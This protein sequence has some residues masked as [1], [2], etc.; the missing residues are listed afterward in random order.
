MNRYRVD[1]MTCRACADALGSALR[2]RAHHLVFGID[3]DI[4]VVT[5]I[6]GDAG[7][8]ERVLEAATADAGFVYRGPLASAG[9]TS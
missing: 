5:L 9:A 6:D 7:E 8:A 2:R 4:G 1:G 3:S